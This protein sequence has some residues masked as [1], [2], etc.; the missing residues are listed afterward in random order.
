[1][2]LL[3]NRIREAAEWF[4]A[5]ASRERW[6]LVIGS[7]VAVY[8]I[9]ALLFLNPLLA[10][11][12]GL[13]NE[14]DGVQEQ[15]D[16][17]QQR[18]AGAADTVRSGQHATFESRRDALQS[19]LQRIATRLE[20]REAALVPPSQTRR[21]LQ[22]LLRAESELHLV[23]LQTLSPRPLEEAADDPEKPEGSAPAE[24]EAVIYR[25]AVRLE[26]VGD[27]F[28]TMRYLEALETRGRGLLLDALEYDVEQ[29]PQARITLTVYTLSFDEAWIGV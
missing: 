12:E 16:S 23:S 8:S 4:D 15:F 18:A 14:I 3:E 27:Y 2:K 7:A 10:E 29:Y 5:R 19:E 9:I 22:D 21:V 24:P 25:H 1:M 28:A 17:L 11:R 13:L 6:I 20:E 26:A